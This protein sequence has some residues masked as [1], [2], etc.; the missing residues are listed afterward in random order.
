MDTPM[1][2][3]V[4]GGHGAVIDHA[5]EQGRWAYMYYVMPD[6]K[7]PTPSEFL[8][9][10]RRWSTAPGCLDANQVGLDQYSIVKLHPRKRN[11]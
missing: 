4:E 2:L 8:H 10:T 11:F 3:P 6:I 7:N 9:K 1:G 5:L